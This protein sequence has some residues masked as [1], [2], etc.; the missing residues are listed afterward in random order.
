M[1]F[2]HSPLY[3]LFIHSLGTQVCRTGHKGK[4]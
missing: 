1:Q 2:L 3:E 4:V